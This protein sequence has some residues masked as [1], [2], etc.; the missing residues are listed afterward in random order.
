MFRLI[1]I[2]LFIWNKKFDCIIFTT[3]GK[4]S[5]IIKNTLNKLKNIY[6]KYFISSLI[7]IYSYKF[8]VFIYLFCLDSLQ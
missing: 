7:S 6:I 4:L 2:V 8:I 3:I 1:N 5:I